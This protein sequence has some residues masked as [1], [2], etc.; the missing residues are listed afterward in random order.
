MN[1]KGKSVLD[2]YDEEMMTFDEYLKI[3]SRA[4]RRLKPLR[5]DL[6]TE[7]F[8]YI[9]KINKIRT[10]V[11]EREVEKILDTED[12]YNDEDPNEDIKVNLTDK[13]LNDYKWK[14]MFSLNEYQNFFLDEIK[15]K[16]SSV[17]YRA[18]LKRFRQISKI[19]F[20]SGKINFSSIAN[21]L[22]DY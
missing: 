3:Q 14:N 19:C 11:M 17:N 10:S 4:E 22:G 20:A 21:N 16:I 18:M 9:Q 5:G 2:D 13:G 15:G 8:D 12:R 7:F 6:T 1:Q